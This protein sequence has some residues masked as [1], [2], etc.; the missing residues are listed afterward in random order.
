[1]ESRVLTCGSCAQEGG[2][3]EHVGQGT[4]E[5]MERYNKEIYQFSSV[6]K[7]ANDRATALS[8]LFSRG[9]VAFPGQRNHLCTRYN[10]SELPIPVHSWDTSRARRTCLKEFFEHRHTMYHVIDNKRSH[11]PEDHTRNKKRATTNHSLVARSACTARGPSSGPPR[12]TGRRGWSTALIFCR[13]TAA[14][15]TSSGDPSSATP[16]RLIVR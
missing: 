16:P 7:R 13:G 5:K 14:T 4:V 12:K 15:K 3:D 11:D 8:R 10:T 2:G 6:H 1:M 9:A